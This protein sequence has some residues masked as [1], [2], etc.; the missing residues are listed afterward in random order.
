MKVKEKVERCQGKERKIP[1]NI[2]ERSD[3]NHG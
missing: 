3:E 1:M 2:K